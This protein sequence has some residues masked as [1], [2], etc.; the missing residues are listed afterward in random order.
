MKQILIV[1]AGPAGIRAAKIFVDAGIKP[2]VVDEAERAGGQI[3]RRPPKGFGRSAKELY[4]SEAAKAV[5]L[6]HIFDKMV[7]KNQVTYYPR[8]SV[9]AL[10]NGQAHVLGADGVFQCPY[11]K[12]II[13]T[14]AT[15]RL[16]PVPGWQAPGVYSL[17][18]AQIAL[19]A[20]G[21]ALGQRIV[22]AGAGPLLILLAHQ[23]VKAGATL[24]AVLDTSPRTAQMRGLFD[25][26]LSR[27]VTTL[28]G[29][30]MRLGIARYYRGAVTL[31]EIATDENGPVAVSWL[32]RR[33]RQYQSKCDMVGLGWHLR[34]DTH[35]ADLAGARFQRDERFSQWLPETDMFGRAT[36]DVYLAGDGMRILGADGAECAG[37]LAAIG[38]L[39]D[40]ALTAPD[41]SSYLG[42]LKR[43]MRFAKGIARA[44]PWP[45]K[46]IRTLSDETVLCRCEGVTV[47]QLRKT[48]DWSGP[49][50]NRAKSLGRVGMGRCQGRYCQLAGAEIIAAE[51]NL[52]VARVGRLRSQPPARPAPISAYVDHDS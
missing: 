37:A 46:M 41:P 33:G 35:L 18:A 51:V 1:G 36:K 9:V 44:F 23:L 49:E 15:D 2:I 7:Q 34:A 27:P 31:R 3:Y 43:M 14:G 47:G 28:R 50:A 29:I 40:M 45:E 6:H 5:A 8:C 39:Q 22:L 48:T 4:G 21:V 11:D 38:C 30:W 42:R 13:A 12:L 10:A 17:G 25:M 19:K 16:A 52:P 20:Q 32:D 26:F 24:E